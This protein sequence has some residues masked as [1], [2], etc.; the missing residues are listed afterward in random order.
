M[1][2]VRW[3]LCTRGKPRR[4]FIADQAHDRSKPLPGSKLSS[5]I[6]GVWGKGREEGYANATLNL[7][8][9]GRLMTADEDRLPKGEG[10]VH[11]QGYARG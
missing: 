1:W 11:E 8:R 4:L 5:F 10:R 9:D 3:R 2:C 7:P 6:D